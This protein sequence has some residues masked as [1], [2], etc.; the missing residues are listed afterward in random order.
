ML[1]Q[2]LIILFFASIIF[3]FAACGGANKDDLAENAA[4]RII[5]GLQSECWV[6]EPSG[7][8]SLV[9]L[10]N[11][12]NTQERFKNRITKEVKTTLEVL[13]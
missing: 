13:D 12:P 5:Y 3:W 6:V 1:R 11:A 2:S 9:P 7:L 4:D 8:T 10:S